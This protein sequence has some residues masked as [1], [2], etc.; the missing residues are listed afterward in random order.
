MQVFYLCRNID[1]LAC[2]DDVI[3]DMCSKKIMDRVI[4]GDVG[5]GKTEVILRAAYLALLNN[6]Q[7]V[8]IVPTTVLA[9][10]HLDTFKKR[11]I[12]YSYNISLLTRVIKNKQKLQYYNDIKS[13]KINIIIGTHALL[14]SDIQFK[15]IG[16]YIIDEE[17]KFGVKHKEELKSRIDNIDVLSLS[18]T[19]I[20][21]TLNSTLS[22]IKDMSVINTPP[23]GRKNINTTIIKLEKEVLKSYFDREINRGGQVLYV[24][25]NIESMDDQIKYLMSICSDYKIEKIH[26]KLKASSVEKIMLKFLD[27]EIDILVC[28]SIIESGL[29]MDN[30]NTII[31]NDA[32]N[33]GLSQLHQIRGRV[34]RK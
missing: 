22:Q 29:D 25:N 30:V 33:F 20:P 14:N 26:G 15:N 6:K 19:P 11:F 1:Q 4:C 21:R 9:N 8:V 18:A 2:I 23:I 7:V 24:H 5:F 28:T 13:G 34:G 17:H 3:K 32:E 16:L 10:Q 27:N 12:N 31:I